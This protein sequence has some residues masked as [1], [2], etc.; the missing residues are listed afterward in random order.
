MD[1]TDHID[2]ASE[3]LGGRVLAANDE[4]FAPKENLL[5]AAAPIWIADKYTDVGKWMDGWE[6][7]RRR[8]PGYDW[9]IVKLGL[10]GTI[11]GVVVDTAHF[12]GNYPESCEIEACAAEGDPSASQLEKC[13]TTWI[14]LLPKLPL[15]GDTRNLF[16]CNFASRVTHL[17]FKIFPDGGVA[18]LRVHGEVVPDWAALERHGG[19][20]DLAAVENGGW[21]VASSD[22]FFGSPN[23]L[24]LPGRS[25]GMHDGWETRRRRGPGHDWCIVRLGAPGQIGRVEVDTSFFKGNFPESCSLEVCAAARD[26]TDPQA[27]NA[28]PW[29]EILS[30]TTLRAD[31]LHV[32]EKELREAGEVTHARLNIYPDGGVARLRLSGKLGRR[33]S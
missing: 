18:R 17:R 19:E 32:Y 5:K 25:A 20:L 14:A 31:S 7:R 11:R 1:F 24:I 28:L 16:P 10:P 30:R 29:K 33:A 27:L 23:N 2:L 26:L 22:K 12:K 3:R 4:F 21:V 6:T 9:C 8:T 15:G 13:E